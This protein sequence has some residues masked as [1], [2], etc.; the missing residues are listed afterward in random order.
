MDREAIESFL[1]EK[2]KMDVKVYLARLSY[3]HVDKRLDNLYNLYNKSVEEKSSYLG[4]SQKVLMMEMDKKPI[5]KQ[6]SELHFGYF[7]KMP[8]FPL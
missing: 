2:P 1:K 4:N 7:D 5:M 3:V 8:V 6:D